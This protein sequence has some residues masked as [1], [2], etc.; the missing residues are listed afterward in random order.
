[1]KLQ[2]SN[3][4]LLYSL[5][6]DP[7]I[8]LAFPAPPQLERETRDITPGYS[9]NDCNAR[10]VNLFQRT[11]ASSQNPITVRLLAR[12][13]QNLDAFDRIFN[14]RQKLHFKRIFVGLEACEERFS[15]Q[16]LEDCQVTTVSHFRAMVEHVAQRRRE[17]QHVIPFF[18][19]KE[20]HDKSQGDRCRHETGECNGTGSEYEQGTPPYA[21][22]PP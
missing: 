1:M 7:C 2:T 10:G 12:W 19:Q 22:L 20:I 17:I 13:T 8:A 14:T 11:Q 15:D 4:P 18:Q 6:R 5:S 21:H 16:A 9:S 3:Y